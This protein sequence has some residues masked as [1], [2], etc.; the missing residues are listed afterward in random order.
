MN[1]LF[2]DNDLVE[3]EPDYIEDEGYNEPGNGSHSASPV[4]IIQPSADYQAQSSQLL[5]PKKLQNPC[6]ASKERMALHKELLMN[7]RLWVKF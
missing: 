6:V 2:T 5:Q 3:P 1:A 4:H 7:Q